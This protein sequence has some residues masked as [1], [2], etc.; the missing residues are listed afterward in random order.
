MENEVRKD[1]ALLLR[2]DDIYSIGKV[3]KLRDT[4]VILDGDKLWL[5]VRNAGKEEISV[6]KPLPAWKRYR[7]KGKL[8]FSAG[9]EVPSATLPNSREMSLSEFLEVRQPDSL[10][11]FYKPEKVS[12]S[13]CRSSRS[14]E[15][16]AMIVNAKA[17]LAFCESCLEV[18]IKNLKYLVNDGRLFITGSPLPTVPGNYY[19]KMKRIFLPAGFGIEQ[20]IVEEMIDY[21]LPGSSMWLW[22]SPELEPVQLAPFENV[23]LSSL[24]RTLIKSGADE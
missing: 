14:E 24:R 8:L 2:K 10:Q 11:S 16:T 17:F 5:L 19:Y 20:Q 3:R 23:S 13:L 9:N 1:Y 15:S 4:S 18:R 22:E 21:L 7:A 12:L 6:L